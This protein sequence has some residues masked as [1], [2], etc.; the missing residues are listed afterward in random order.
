M[1]ESARELDL[2]GEICPVPLLK[3]PEVLRQMTQGDA[4]EV[5]VDMPCAKEN[6]PAQM[7]KE[8]H[9]VRLTENG[10]DLEIIIYSSAFIIR[11]T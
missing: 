8:G 9:S 11:E 4:L 1:V 10:S 3:T 6:M 2:R 7:K 5:H